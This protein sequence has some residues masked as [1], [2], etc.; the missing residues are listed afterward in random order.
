MGAHGVLGRKGMRMNGNGCR[1][2]DSA[3]GKWG[4][5]EYGLRRIRVQENEDE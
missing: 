4:E 1:E 5:E 2:N 3:G